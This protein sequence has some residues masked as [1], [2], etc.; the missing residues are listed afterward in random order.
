MLNLLLTLCSIIFALAL[1]AGNGAQGFLNISRHGLALLAISTTHFNGNFALLI[2]LNLDP[3]QLFPP[4]CNDSQIS[5]ELETLDGFWVAGRV[6]SMK[7]MPRTV[8]PS[9]P[10]P[11]QQ[12]FHRFGFE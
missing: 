3:F 5:L 10:D 1:T 8:P 6:F 11:I 12:I 2:D 9:F 4:Q 7:A